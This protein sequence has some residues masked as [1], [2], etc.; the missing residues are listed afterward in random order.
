MSPINRT[1]I[2]IIPGTLLVRKVKLARTCLTNPETISENT[3][4]LLLS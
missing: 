3:L 1:V 4:R 2:L